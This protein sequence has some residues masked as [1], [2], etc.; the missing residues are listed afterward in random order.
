[1][2]SKKPRLAGAFR[3]PNAFRLAASTCLA[4][5]VIL[6]PQGICNAQEEI[7]PKKKEGETMARI[8]CVQSLTE[9]EEEA[10]LATKSEKGDWKEYGKT[11][12]R[13]PFI[14]DWMVVRSGVSHL[15]RRKGE[16]MVSIGSFEI[17]DGLKRAI[18][19]MLPDVKK[20]IYRI[21]VI[22]PSSLGFQKGKALILNYGNVP[23][24]VQ[25]GKKTL[26]VAPGKQGVQ[27]IVANEDGMY[28]MLIGYVD[29][30]KK[31]V[32]CYDRFVSSNANTRKFVLLFPDQDT[33]LRAMSLSEFGPFE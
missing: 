19:V 26:L 7:H 1:M 14:S 13:T 24:V 4:M 28:R 15:V 25:I 21:Q 23:A 20:N 6:Y 16:E 9:E 11:I 33:G 2:H 18:L 10:I 22:D 30:D 12:L 29:K 32:P 5:I 8:L 17:K 3:N 27:N 31:I